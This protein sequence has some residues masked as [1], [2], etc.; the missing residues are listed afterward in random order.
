METNNVKKIGPF[1]GDQV[2][3]YL[4]PEKLKQARAN[5]SAGKITE[6]ELEKK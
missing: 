4:R 6:D 5:F 2:G 3:S 1:R